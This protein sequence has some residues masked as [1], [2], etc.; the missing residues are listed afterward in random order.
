MQVSLCKDKCFPI[1]V[2]FSGERRL[3]TISEA[4]EWRDKLDSAL[5]RLSTSMK[6]NKALHTDGN[7]ESS[8]K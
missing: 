2:E 5:L 3:F 1:V 8:V 4:K 7:T 6:D